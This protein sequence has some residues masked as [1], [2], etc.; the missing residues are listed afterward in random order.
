M[1]RVLLL[2]FVVVALVGSLRFLLGVDSPKVEN[3]YRIEYQDGRVEI[4]CS[5]N[6]CFLKNSCC[7]CWERNVL[8]GPAYSCGVS[9][10]IAL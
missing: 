2:I 6:Q 8:D 9:K 7:N 1:K 5:F 10:V 4:I 3:V